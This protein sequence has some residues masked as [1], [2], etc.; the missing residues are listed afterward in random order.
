MML[1]PNEDPALIPDAEDEVLAKLVG[2]TG[3]AK[4]RMMPSGVVV[5]EKRQYDAV[6]ESEPIDPGSYVI[7]IKANKLNVIVRQIAPDTG[8]PAS[9]SGY[10]D[11]TNNECKINDPFG[12]QN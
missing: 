6:S 3:T 7:V 9:I 10:T 12:D 2:K 4:S 1:D 8:L 11:S 5:I